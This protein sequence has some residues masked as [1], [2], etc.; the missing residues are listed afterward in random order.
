MGDLPY[1]TNGLTAGIQGGTLG[2][3]QLTVLYKQNDLE[4]VTHL[5]LHEE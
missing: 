5:G 2:L 1:M 4:Q 3:E